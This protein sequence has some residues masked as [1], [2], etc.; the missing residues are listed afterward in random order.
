MSVSRAF[1]LAQFVNVPAN[2][3]DGVVVNALGPPFTTQFK[4]VV[5]SVNSGVTVSSSVPAANAQGQILL[6][7]AGPGF[8]W[9]LGTNPAAA[10]SVPPPTAQNQVLMADAVPTWQPTTATTLVQL[11]GACM[12]SSGGAFAAAAKLTFATTASV[13]TCIDGV[14]PTKS[15]LD[16]FTL[17]C[18]VFP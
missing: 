17:D 6:S 12:L 18:G 4:P 16:N 3:N 5:T 11:G 10:A 1:D 15:Q 9:G 2:V 14:D 7:G 13:S 8:A